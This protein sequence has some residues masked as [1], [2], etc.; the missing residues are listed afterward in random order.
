[1]GLLHVQRCELKDH[2]KVME[3]KVQKEHELCYQEFIKS[4]LI[5]NL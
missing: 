3:L 4:V 5:L 1:M 2:E